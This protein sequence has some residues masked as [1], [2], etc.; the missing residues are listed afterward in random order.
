MTKIS[1]TPTHVAIVPDD[2]PSATGYIVGRCVPISDTGAP[3]MLQRDG[4]TITMTVG[5][6]KRACVSA[7]PIT[8]VRVAAAFEAWARHPGADPTLGDAMNSFTIAATS[9]R[10]A[11]GLF[12]YLEGV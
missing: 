2:D 4:D 11:A 12:K 7:Q 5:D 8:H 9:K 3:A 6:F 1:V 10:L